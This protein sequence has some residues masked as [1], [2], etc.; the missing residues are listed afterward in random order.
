MKLDF[1][2][3]MDHF[4]TPTAELADVVLPASTCLERDDIQWMYSGLFWNP[5]VAI[6]KVIE[7]LW[8]SKD[9]TDVFIDILKRVNLDY[10]FSNK[11]EMLF[12]NLS[13]L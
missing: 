13:V 12:N 5:V 1:I 8:E 7:P 10:G 3:V 11:K 2:S 9:D 4:M 6:P